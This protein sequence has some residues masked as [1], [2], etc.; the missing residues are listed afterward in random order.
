MLALADPRVVDVPELGPLRAR[1][2]LAEVVAEAEDPLLRAGA[3]LVAAGAAHRGVEAVL[4]DGVEQ[5]RRLQLVARGAR[6]G[7]LGDP[8]AV[9][10]VLNACDDQSLVELGHAPVAEL[11]HLGE[12]VAGVDVHDRE[13]EA[14]RA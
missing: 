6:A 11:D 4:G 13:R 3:L 12:V 2:P 1:V 9:D 14:R 5:R 10:R 7:L 8:A